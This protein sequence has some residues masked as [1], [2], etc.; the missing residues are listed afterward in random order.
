[1]NSASEVNYSPQS[2][3]MNFATEVLTFRIPVANTGG[4][5][6]KYSLNNLAQMLDKDVIYYYY[7]IS[8]LP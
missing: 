5:V 7:F 3:T 2:V 1:M 4:V 8:F 6:S